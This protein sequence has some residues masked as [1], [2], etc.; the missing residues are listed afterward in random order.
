MLVDRLAVGLFD[1]AEQ[2]ESA[3]LLWSHSH[4]TKVGIRRSL[5][6]VIIIAPSE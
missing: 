2:A 6:G 5:S 3:Q 4:A 1:I